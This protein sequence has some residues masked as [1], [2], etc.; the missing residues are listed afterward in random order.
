[1]ETY[2]STHLDKFRQQQDPMADIVIEKYSSLDKS[3][4][5]SHL[6][7]LVDNSSTLTDEALPELKN[8]YQSIRKTAQAFDKS[9]LAEGQGFFDH[10]AS[11]IML[12]L[13]FLSLPYCYGAAAGAE[14]LVRSKKILEEPE[15]RLRETAEFVF[16]VTHKH[17]FEPNGKA[18]VSILKVRLRHASTRW[19]IHSAGNWDAEEFG[20]PVNQE[21]MAGTNLSFSLIPIRGLRKLGRFIPP[22]KAIH[23]VSYWNHIGLLLGVDPEL[24][25]TGN[26]EAFLLEKQIRFRHFRPSEAGFQLASSL[27]KYFE[28]ATADT[29]LDGFTKAFMIYL[30]G[31]KISRQIGIEIGN[32]D[33]LVFRPQALFVQFRNFL[34]ESQDSYAKAYSRFKAMS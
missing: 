34:F 15:I 28:K 17:A 24:L 11:D 10:Y 25:P 30:L 19:Y 26:K 29:P 2:R 12:L 8:L 9:T 16:D 1:M 31:D 18:L 21:D 20:Q 33:R 32:Y 13:G 3:L 27:L 23:Y 7:I 5:K 14:V 6:D 22:E 4:L